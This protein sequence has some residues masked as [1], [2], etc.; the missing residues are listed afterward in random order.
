MNKIYRFL[1]LAL[2]ASV[3][4]T[5]F[6][7][8]KRTLETKVADILAQMPTHD[9]QHRDRLMNEMITLGQKGLEEFSDL[10]VAPGTGDDTNAR[11][12][13]G[14]LAKFVGQSGREEARMMVSKAF[15][16]AI[17]KTSD[18]EEK[19]FFF[20]HLNFFGGDEAVPTAVTY[21]NNKRL[22]EPAIAFLHSVG[23]HKAI[24]ALIDA[25]DGLGAKQKVTAVKTLG[26]TGVPC[27]L[28]AITPLVGSGDPDLQQEVLYALAQIA[29][30]SSYKTLMSAA[31]ASGYSYERTQATPDLLLY[32][33]RLGEKGELDASGKI[34]RTIM[35]KCSGAEQMRY[36]LNA[37]SI[38]VDQQGYEVL[39]MLLD[40]MENP[41]KVYRGAVMR[42][43]AQITD[44]GA[45]RQWME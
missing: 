25:L 8:D 33:Q 29:D 4:L 28:K 39:D 10:I 41:D 7:Q 19:A 27:A 38:L 30:L 6:A 44:I 14:S 21:L 36:A 11:F 31:K 23:S 13:L 24:H 43:A 15:T 16:D 18:K 32:A 45:T 37:M 34:C 26:E 2:L 5:G 20:Y 40:G 42:Y 35:K 9:R 1:I 17:A 3:S 12:A 22:S